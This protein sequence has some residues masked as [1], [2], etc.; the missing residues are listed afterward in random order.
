MTP[1]PLGAL[2]AHAGLAV[3]PDAD[4]P[5]ACRAARVVWSG[6]TEPGDGIAG[7]LLQGCDPVTAY[8]LILTSDAVRHAAEVAECRVDDMRKARARWMPRADV[9]LLA[10]ALAAARRAGARLLT[11]EDRVWP[12]RVDDLGVHAPLC[13]WARGDPTLLEAPAGAIALVGARAA[14][15][16]GEHVAGELAAGV[17]ADGGVI[18]S[19]AAYGVDAAAHRAALG[20]AGTT[21]AFLAGGCD[22]LYPGGNARLLERIIAAGVVVAESPCGTAPTRW[23]FLAR[24][25]LIAAASDATIVVEAGARS[26]ALNTAHHAATLGRPV[27]AVPGPVTSATSIGTHRLLREEDATCVTSSDEVLELIGRVAAPVLE[28]GE[29]TGDRQR[30]RDAMSVR[31]FRDA[32]TI[33]ARSGMA[34]ADVEAH[35]GAMLLESAVESDP[36]GWRLT[37]SARRG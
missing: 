9:G 27:G 35:L 31:A 5:A 25:R 26:G 28:L 1:P 33:A 7:A 22:R 11:P 34:T 2:F 8:E 17:V 4:D 24:N 13:L 12:R 30:V 10:D 29:T 6:L 19:G 3:A 23:R 15:A 36:A 20:A 14:T 18:V 32:A 21:V 16:Y 37:R